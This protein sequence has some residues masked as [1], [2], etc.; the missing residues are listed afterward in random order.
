MPPSLPLGRRPLDW[1]WMA[2]FAVNLGFVTYVVDV[3]QLIVADPTRF[4]YPLW[5]PGPLVD[6]VHW[7]GKNYDPPL[8]ARAP[9]WKATIWI[10]ALFF[11]PF[12]AVALYAFAKGKPWIRIPTII[13]ASVMLTNVTIIL[14]EEFWGAHATPAPWVV[15]GANAAWLIVPMAMLIK[16]CPTAQPFADGA[17]A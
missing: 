13:W 16:M 17:R 11:G 8:M 15:L 2:F 14:S 12:Y 6:L 5:P 4:A 3:E 9:Y 7:W 10:D 1:I